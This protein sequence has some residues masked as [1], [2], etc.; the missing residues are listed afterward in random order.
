[1]LGYDTLMNFYKTTFSLMQHH[2]YNLYDVENMIPW[3]KFIYIDLLR[4]H[5]QQQED[6]QKAKR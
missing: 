4:Q 6:H 3:E 5:I 1:M 2:G